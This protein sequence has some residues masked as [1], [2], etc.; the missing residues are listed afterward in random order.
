MASTTASFAPFP[1]SSRSTPA[2][3]AINVNALDEAADSA[4]FQNRLGVR[5]PDRETL[6]RGACTPDQLLDAASAEPGSF[7]IDHGK[8]NGAS[9]G[10]R[11]RVGKRKYMLKTDVA[12][13]PERPS[14]ASAIGSA[15]YHAVGFNTSC[16]QVIFFDRRVLTLTPGLV[17]T[18][19]SGVT[20]PFDEGALDHVLDASTKNGDL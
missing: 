13:Q 6:L 3:E 1:G 5:H 16:E 15:I 14:A 7:I 18:S 17:V 4:W 8:D 19:N 12:N 11:I 9:L 2:R 20:K 10:F